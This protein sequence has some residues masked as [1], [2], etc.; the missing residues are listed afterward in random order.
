VF[1]GVFHDEDTAAGGRPPTFRPAR[2]VGAADLA[3]VLQTIQARIGRLLQRRELEDE[4]ALALLAERSPELAATQ[5]ASVQGRLAFGPRRGQRITRVGS[6]GG[7]PFTQPPRPDCVA[8]EGFSLH[9]GV[10]VP[11][12]DRERL[13]R[14]CRYMARPAVAT[15]RLSVLPDGRIAY[16]LRRA[17]SDGTT[18]VVFEP[19]TFLEKLAALIPPPRAHLVTYHGV[20][21]P[22]APMRRRI[23]PPAGPGARRGGAGSGGRRYR[24]AE[25]LKRVFAVDVLSC[26]LCG[27]RRRVLALI[28][29]G[30]VVRAML[31]CLG[32]PTEP[33]RIHPARGPPEPEWG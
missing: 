11:G 5:A 17:W 4:S 21:A 15:E 20:L 10:R 32:L 31:T 12:A 2:R 14:L 22:A 26:G 25:L 7:T 1:D 6:P 3:D 29:S 18:A 30:C 27:G 24:W 33:P 28:T 8:H 16:D 19:L 13:E 23:V 9:A